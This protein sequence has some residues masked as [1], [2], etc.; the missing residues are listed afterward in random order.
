M[1]GEKRGGV[2]SGWWGGRGGTGALGSI[3]VLGPGR[4]RR[5]D[6]GTEGGR[7]GV[8]AAWDV[9][10]RSGGCVQFW[11]RCVQFFAECVQYPAGCVHFG[12]AGVQ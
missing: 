5:D 7:R 9:L 1:I 12:G 2:G 10:R 3:G 6:G 8:G 11:G 4:G